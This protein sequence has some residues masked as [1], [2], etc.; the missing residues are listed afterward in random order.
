MWT[1]DSIKNVLYVIR[2]RFLIDI[3]SLSRDSAKFILRTIFGRDINRLNR[4][5]L[6]EYDFISFDVFDTLIKRSVPKPTDV[7]DLISEESGFKRRRIEAE[8]IARQGSDLED[9]TL[10]DIYAHLPGCDIE[11]EIK[12]ERNVCYANP[13]LLSFFN[14]AKDDG[15]HIIITSDMYLSAFVIGDILA[16]AGYTGYEQLYV[17]SEY[18]LTKK[19]GH[20][21]GSIIEDLGTARIMHIGDNGLSDYVRARQAGLDSFLYRGRSS[22]SYSQDI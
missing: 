7:F 5:D 8:R 3:M 10:E 21:Y 12:T 17:S 15:R 2:I 4:V 18:G 13:E 16:D 1:F 9:I 6:T 22:A 14:M 11:K 19:S 20:L